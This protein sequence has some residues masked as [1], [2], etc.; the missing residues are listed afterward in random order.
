MKRFIIVPVVLSLL[1]VE[2]AF[3]WGKMGHD[4]VAYIA[5]C[6]LTPK[7]QKRIDRILDGRSIVYYASWMDEIRT[8]PAYQHTTYWHTGPVNE[9]LRYDDS[10]LSPNGNVIYGLET[11]LSKLEN[12]KSLDDS[13]LAVSVRQIVHMIGDMHCPVHAK[14]PDIKGKYDIELFGKVY[15]YHAVWDSHIIERRHKWHYM[16]WQQQL[17]R[18][19]KREKKAICEGDVRDWF[20]DTASVAR[21]IYD[22]VPR[23]SS[24]D[25]DFINEMSPIAERQILKAGYRL[26]KVLNG[27][28]G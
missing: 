27:I 21:Q 23:G 1:C 2:S 4:A 5:E 3:G 10:L 28:F 22:S 11:V 15:P 9:Q 12:W 19:S 20:F 17:D 18:C 25:N 24:C 13:T 26:A 16:E 14:L 8:T 6:N 7:A